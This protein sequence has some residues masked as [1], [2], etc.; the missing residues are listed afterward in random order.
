MSQAID[1]TGQTWGSL[2]VIRRLPNVDG[3]RTNWLV[4]CACGVEKAVLGDVMRRGKVKTCGGLGCK[5][6]GKVT[7]GGSGTPLYNVWMSMRARCTNP[8][9]PAY[10]RYG[11]RGIAVC[12]R[13]Q[14]FENFVTDMGERPDGM[15]LER[16]DNDLGYE[17]SNVRWATKKE[18]A[19]NT[20]RNTRIETA[21]GVLSIP[22]AA[23]I[24]G[25][26]YGAIQER[27]AAGWAGDRLIEPNKRPRR[28]S[29]TS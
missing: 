9:V 6:G 3:K 1:M 21:V 14:E 12:E 29:T 16:I 20:R 23:A 13:W 2:L 17:P 11:G 5:P 22:E 8:K 28:K 19:N 15:T 7:H 18:Q 24:A 25:V 4:R 10:A 26:T 27:R